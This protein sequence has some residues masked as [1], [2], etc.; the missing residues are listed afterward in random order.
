MGT[1]AGHLAGLFAMALIAGMEAIE[2]AWS[3]QSQ[4]ET[5]TAETVAEEIAA[6]DG[7]STP[8]TAP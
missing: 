1:H 4:G 2:S 3:L 8:S 7:R 5:E 6:A